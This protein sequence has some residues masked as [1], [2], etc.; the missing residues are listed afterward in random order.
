MEI[1]GILQLS[2]DVVQTY[3]QTL[4]MHGMLAAR[5]NDVQDPVW[6][7]VVK[8]IRDNGS[9]M[10]GVIEDGVMVA[11]FA[12][13]HIQEKAYLIHFSSMPTRPLKESIPMIRK[14]LFQ[15][16]HWQDTDSFLI[17]TLIGMTPKINRIACIMVIKIGFRFKT[18]LPLTGPDKTAC[19][20]TQLQREDTD[21]WG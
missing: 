18:V 14:V 9:Q 21:G 15:I 11:D 20:L 5:F 7:D 2:P 13:Q 3:F 4:Y 19:M 17:D 12:L 8:V 6:A 1:K 10:Y 16:M